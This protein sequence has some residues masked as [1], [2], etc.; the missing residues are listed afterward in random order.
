MRGTQIFA[1]VETPSLIYGCGCLPTGINCCKY[2][3]SRE[4]GDA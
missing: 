1:R 2:G 4:D 3:G